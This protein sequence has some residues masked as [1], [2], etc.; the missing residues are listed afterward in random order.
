VA[1]NP[2]VAVVALAMLS[3]GAVDAATPGVDPAALSTQIAPDFSRPD[4]NHGNLSLSALRGHVVLLNFWATWCGPCLAEV[5][6]FAEWQRK[7]A[8]HGLQIV[9][10]SLDDDEAPVDAAYRKYRL[11]YPV[12][13][14]DVHLAELYGGV[15]G[16]P[17]IFLID[18][19]GR[20]RF[21]HQG[22]TDLN[23]IE[24]EIEALLAQ[25][26]A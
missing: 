10:I 22:E 18:R 24:H 25:L 4:L 20:I 13:M 9:G 5:P 7:Y 15:Y 19:S 2:L 26:P 1:A 23:Q 16:L 11:N 17:V 6:Q 21:R 3:G 14:G 12:V 8:D